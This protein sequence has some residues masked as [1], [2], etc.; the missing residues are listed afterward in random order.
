MIFCRISVQAIISTCGSSC[1]D[2]S[3]KFPAKNGQGSAY[4]RSIRSILFPRFLIFKVRIF[5]LDG[6]I[7]GYLFIKVQSLNFLSGLVQK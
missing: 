3:N 5:L 7:N 1:S 6:Q 4:P 2:G